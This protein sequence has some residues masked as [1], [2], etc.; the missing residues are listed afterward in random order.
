VFSVVSFYYTVTSGFI[1][2]SG[3]VVAYLNDRI[4]VTGGH[5]GWFPGGVVVPLS[6]RKVWRNRELFVYIRRR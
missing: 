5:R 3:M 6:P 4:G 2:L 1:I